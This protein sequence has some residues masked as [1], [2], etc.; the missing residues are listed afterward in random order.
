MIGK[1][2]TAEQLDFYTQRQPLLDYIVTVLRWF[3]ITVEVF[4][5]RDFG[6]R[7]L[8]RTKFV[9]GLLVLLV[10]N[11]FG[12]LSSGFGSAMQSF[13]PPV[14]DPEQG[15]WVQPPPESAPFDL[16]ISAIYVVLLLYLILGGYH[17]F[18]IWWRNGTG[19]P[20]HSYD[21]GLTWL[22]PVGVMVLGV[23]NFIIGLFV[24]LYALMLPVHERAWLASA[25]PFLRDARTFAER[26]LE[27]LTLFLLAI[28]FSS[29]GV[30][31]VPTWLFVS[32]LAIFLLTTIRHEMER[33]QVLD[34]QDRRIESEYMKDAMS[35][36]TESLRVPYGTRK[37]IFELANQVEKSPAGMDAIRQSNPTIAEAM[38]ALNPKLKNMGK[39][40]P[41]SDDPGSSQKPTPPSD[42]SP[43]ASSAEEPVPVQEEIPPQSG[44]GLSVDDAM[45]SLKKKPNK[46]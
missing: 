6:E 34:V 12:K 24:K 18:R 37:A 10:L 38:E 26:F 31:M 43:P 25:L 33:N 13:R 28:L 11:L 23:P 8:T 39:N 14:F 46:K 32:T 3:A 41:P 4:L 36:D 40:P 5:R 27:P 16:G 29:L 35:G 42:M 1:S 17:T 44:S 15:I 45:K 22:E 9:M 7:Y 19:R 21:H 2:E 30:S 20:L